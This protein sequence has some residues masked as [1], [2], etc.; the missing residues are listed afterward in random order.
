M[1]RGPSTEL[2][3]EDKCEWKQSLPS[4][5]L[6]STW[7]TQTLRQRNKGRLTAELGPQCSVGPCTAFRNMRSG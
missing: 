2:H 5:T 7:G 6:L 3:P 1:Y 4:K